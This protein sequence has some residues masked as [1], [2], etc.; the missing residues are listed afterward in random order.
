MGNNGFTVVEAEKIRH[1]LHRKVHADRAEQKVI[2]ATI[3]RLGF[4]ISDFTYSPEGFTPSDFDS[5][6]ERGE[7]AITGQLSPK[8]PETIS[9]HT[10]RTTPEIA[11][12]AL[13]RPDTQAK[14][15]LPS[16]AS[17][18]FETLEGIKR[19]GFGGFIL[20]RISRQ[21][22]AKTCRGS[23]GFTLSCEQQRGSQYFFRRA[24]VVFSRGAPPQFPFRNCTTT[25]LTG[26]SC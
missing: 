19:Y 5:L 16:S 22:V 8:T 12:K 7:V 24:L 6:I 20:F 23:P 13:P 10:P 3:R 25:G 18:D 21:L 11:N 14:Q 26:R 17:I 9:A 15:K 4:Y 2:R 1:L